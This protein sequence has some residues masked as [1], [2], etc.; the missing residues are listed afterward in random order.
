MGVYYNNI[1]PSGFR[2]SLLCSFRYGYPSCV[3]QGRV[4]PCLYKGF[5]LLVLGIIVGFLSFGGRAAARG[6]PNTL[7]YEQICGRKM[8]RPYMIAA[9]VL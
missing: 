8:F 4:Y 2:F 5:L 1:T 6:A 3:R 7:L 9:G